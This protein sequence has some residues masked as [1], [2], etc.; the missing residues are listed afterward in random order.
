MTDTVR[1]PGLVG[2]SKSAVTTL[3]RAFA[4]SLVGIF[5]FFAVGA[6]LFSIIETTL[7]KAQTDLSFWKLLFL[8]LAAILAELLGLKKM[9]IAWWNAQPLSTVAWFGIWIV[10]FGFSLYGALFAA[11]DFQAKREGVQ[12]AAYVR[13]TNAEDQLA[14]AKNERK[15]IEGR[16]SWMQTAVNNKPVRTVEAA[17]ADIRNAK[18]Q[19]LWD[20]TE[21]C[22]D[23]R[24]RASKA[25]CDRYTQLLT[26]KALAGEKKT[27]EAELKAAKDDIAKYEGVVANG[28]TATTSDATPFVEFVSWS[29]GMDKRSAAFIE[30]LQMSLTNMLLVSLAGLV[31]GLTAI[32]GTPRIRWVDWSRISRALFGGIKV[33]EPMTGFTR[34]KAS[35]A[36]TPVAIQRMEGWLPT[37]GVNGE[38]IGTKVQALA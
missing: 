9:I 30:P 3:T 7:G 15:R 11:G 16:L 35:D 6:A 36:L 23:I 20:N 21:A 31:L 17:D 19:R 4:D 38:I 1:T 12:K 22:T 25:F 10:G 26:E 27:L 28:G 14:D 37:R 18:M 33:D 5:V 2:R 8:G 32:Q 13:E 34:G 24:G 29:T